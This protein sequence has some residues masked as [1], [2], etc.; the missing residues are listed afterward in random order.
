MLV[1]KRLHTFAFS[2]NIF[3]GNIRALHLFYYPPSP[4]FFSSSPF[5]SLKHK[6]TQEN[7]KHE[8]DGKGSQV[9]V[10]RQR[11]SGELVP[12][13]W[14]ERRGQAIAWL[15]ESQTGNQKNWPGLTVIRHPSSIT[16]PL[17]FITTREHMTSTSPSTHWAAKHSSLHTDF[18]GCLEI[19]YK[20]IALILWN[21][22]TT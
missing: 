13:L 18:S 8:M 9:W 10:E 5:L 2:Q 16:S 19:E 3:L 7:N 20:V 15:L 4:L 1:F 17:P 14:E 21:I 12:R 11:H 22:I 6:S